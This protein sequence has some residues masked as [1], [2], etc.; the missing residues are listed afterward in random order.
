MGGLRLKRAHGALFFM[1]NNS[2]LKIMKENRETTTLGGGCFWC[3]EAIYKCLKGVE[4]VLSGYSGGQIKNPAYREVCEGTTGH[5]EVCEIEFD[6]SII[7]FQEILE[8]FW[9]THDPT[10]LNR[11]GNN[12]GTQ[13]RSVIFFHNNTQKL[14]AEASKNNLNKSDY[15]KNPIVTEISAWENFYPAEDIHKD[16]FESHSEEPYCRLIVLPKIK[17][18]KKIFIN[19]L[20]KAED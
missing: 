1:R 14:L 10:T 12:V 8:V 13:Y 16:Y 9:K 6:P 5:V 17:K 15:Y 7:S 18:F 11:Q 3:V 19:K 4:K 20:K 2:Y